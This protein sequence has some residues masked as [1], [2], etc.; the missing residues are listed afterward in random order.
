MSIDTDD[1]TTESLN[2]EAI[3]YIVTSAPEDS[4]NVDDTEHAEAPVSTPS[5]VM[6][7]VDLLRQFAGAHE[8]T[9]DAS[10]MFVG[11]EKSVCMLLVKRMQAKIAGFLTRE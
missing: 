3:I 1:N 6:D 9:K 11:Y 2:D 4:E 5:Q 7:A 10:N 8:G